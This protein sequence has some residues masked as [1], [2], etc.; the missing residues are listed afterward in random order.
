MTS[1]VAVALDLVVLLVSVFEAAGVEAEEALLLELVAA[2]FAVALVGGVEL[3]GLL[4]GNAVPIGV[5]LT[6]TVALGVAVAVA[7]AVA[8]ANG[9]A[10]ANGVAVGLVE[11]AKPDCVVVPD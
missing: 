9:V 7:V 5:G 6:E 3:A 2:G 10:L 1:G 4:F 11:A 8:E